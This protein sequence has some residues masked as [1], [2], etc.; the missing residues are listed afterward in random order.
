MKLSNILLILTLA[1]VGFV[2]TSC[3]RSSDEVWDD[4]KSCSRHMARGIRSLGGKHGDSRA[5][6]CKEDFYTE[7][8]G[9]DG[10]NGSFIPYE[11]EGYDGQMTTTQSSEAPGES[12]STIPGIEAFR[13]PSLDPRLASIFRNVWF[14]YNRALI[15][16]QENENTIQQVAAYMNQ[17][18][19]TYIFVEGHCDERGPETYNLALGARRANVV[20]EALIQQGVNGDRIFTVSYGKERPLVRENHEEAWSK[21]RRAEFK[22]YQ[23]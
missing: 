6:E 10:T 7:D 23:R 13:D 12:G 11:A 4:T 1:L 16:G 8:Q 9:M 18:P 2:F 21:N 20:R 17:H 19:N 3:Q 22:I 15:K 5:V 14:E